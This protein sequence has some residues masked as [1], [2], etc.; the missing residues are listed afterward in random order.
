V[1]APRRLA[2]LLF[3]ASS[4]AACRAIVGIESLTVDAGQGESQDATTD[5][6]PS[7]DAADASD[8]SDAA[9]AS[10]VFDAR[11]CL[12]SNP[13]NPGCH[14]CCRNAYPAQ[15]QLYTMMAINAGCVCLPDGGNCGAV[16]EASTCAPPPPPGNPPPG[17]PPP[18]CV[19]CFEPALS[20]CNPVLGMC[21][22]P[23][24]GCQDLASC[25]TQPGCN[26]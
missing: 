11:S 23:D 2:A 21:E 24:S 1:T 8:A 26:F 15:Q 19:S 10:D 4:L 17:Q 22:Q 12:Q 6:A 16:C 25:L 5:T 9:N 20:A 3:L 18:S 7:T 13:Q 14:P